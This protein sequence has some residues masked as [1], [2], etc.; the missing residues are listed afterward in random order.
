MASSGYQTNKAFHSNYAWVTYDGHIIGRL[1]GIKFRIEKDVE[2]D[3]II[4][5]GGKPFGKP[6]VKYTKF[7]GEFNKGKIKKSEIDKILLLDA[8]GNDH[9]DR[10]GEHDNSN[11]NTANVTKFIDNDQKSLTLFLS[12]FDTIAISIGGVVLKLYEIN[13]TNS[14]FIETNGTFIGKY[15]YYYDKM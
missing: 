11:F 6:L 3:V 10:F 13:I 7:I 14:K 5:S 9:A 2:Y 1:N 4:G 8:I 12:A 15:I